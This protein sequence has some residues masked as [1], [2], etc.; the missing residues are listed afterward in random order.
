MSHQADSRSIFPVEL[1]I[2]YL[3]G[4]VSGADFFIFRHVKSQYAH[5]GSVPHV[6]RQSVRIISPDSFRTR[7]STFAVWMPKNMYRISISLIHALDMFHTL[8]FLLRSGC[9]YHQVS[10]FQNVFRNQRSIRPILRLEKHC[11]FYYLQTMPLPYRN[12]HTVLPM[13]RVDAKPGSL[14]A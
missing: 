12:I 14:L 13:R 1:I 9:Q 8:E 2:F 4:L 3:I 11:R 7:W 10:L 5:N 6:E